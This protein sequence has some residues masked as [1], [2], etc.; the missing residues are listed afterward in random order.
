M[1][2]LGAEERGWVGICESFWWVGKIMVSFP[3]STSKSRD[4]SLYLPAHCPSPEV[5]ET[6]RGTKEEL[7]VS[8][9]LFRRLSRVSSLEGFR[10][11]AGG[12]EE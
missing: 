6:G 4:T 11:H 7:G 12:R 8:R 5:S 3:T 2:A 1:S 9:A 10:P